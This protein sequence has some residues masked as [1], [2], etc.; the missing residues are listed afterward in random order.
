MFGP[1]SPI[2]LPRAPVLLPSQCLAFLAYAGSFCTLKMGAAVPPVCWYPSTRHH[3]PEDCVLF[4]F[5]TDVIIVAVRI[6]TQNVTSHSYSYYSVPL[7]LDEDC[8]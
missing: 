4:V 7:T 8:D 3:I 6:I 2:G 5:A 1:L